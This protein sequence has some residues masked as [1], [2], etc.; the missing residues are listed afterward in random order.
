MYPSTELELHSEKKSGK[1]NW[2][3]VG[4]QNDLDFWTIF[5]GV[6]WLQVHGGQLYVNGLAK[7]EDFVKEKPLYAIHPTVCP[8]CF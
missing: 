1:D 5:L 4:S 7:K 3:V 8:L 6:N 2:A